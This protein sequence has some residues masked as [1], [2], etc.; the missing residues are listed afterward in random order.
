MS[1]IQG[2]WLAS[3]GGASSPALNSDAKQMQELYYFHFC[4]QGNCL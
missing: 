3:V 1:E 4:W 2:V